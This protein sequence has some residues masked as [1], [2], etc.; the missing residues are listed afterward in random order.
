MKQAAKQIAVLALILLVFCAVYR[1]G[2]RNTYIAYMPIPAQLRGTEHAQVRM[3]PETPGIIR[4][5]AARRM[6]DYVRVPVRP[7]GKGETWVVLDDGGET[8]FGM[9][10]FR[11][12]PLGTIYEDV[13][14]GFTGD[15]IVLVTFTV[16][17]LCV[18]AIMF[19]AYR[20]ASGPSFYSYSTIYAAGFSLFALLTGLLMAYV[21]LR[22]ALR[23]QYAR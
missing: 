20:Q 2:V 12:G 15:F 21:T 1:A 5:D 14:G 13:T 22:H 23:P 19:R 6:G 3:V 7:E 9:L 17:C 8:A 10:H 4:Q 18:A 11:V 16:F